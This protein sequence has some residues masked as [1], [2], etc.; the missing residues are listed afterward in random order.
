MNTTDAMKMRNKLIRK[1]KGKTKTSVEPDP[2]KI[3]FAKISDTIRPVWFLKCLRC[4]K[5]FQNDVD[6]MHVPCPQ[7]GAV[8][9]NLNREAAENFYQEWN[10]PAK[11][12]AIEP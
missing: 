10:P 4:R 8:M 5:L 6:S 3:V 7:C 12:E 9:E 1:A 11:K 2:P